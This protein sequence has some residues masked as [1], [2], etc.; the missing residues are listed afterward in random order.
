MHIKL[1]V[2]QFSLGNSLWYRGKLQPR[3]R[4]INWFYNTFYDNIIIIRFSI[5]SCSIYTSTDT[6]DVRTWGGSQRISGRE[7]V[8]RQVIARD[9]LFRAVAVLQLLVLEQRL[10]NERFV[11]R[12]LIT[13]IVWLALPEQWIVVGNAEAKSSGQTLL[14]T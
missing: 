1:T 9:R 5:V 12:R 7:R 6:R 14:W 4:H 10:L 11:A 8:W 13:H 3:Y 2:K